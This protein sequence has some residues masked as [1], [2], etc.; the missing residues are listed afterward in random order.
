MLFDGKK[1]H[2]CVNC[3]HAASI[4]ED[5]VLCKYKGIKNAESHCFRFSYEPLKRIPAGKSEMKIPSQG[6][7]SL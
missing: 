1:Y 5:Y 6:D 7:Y 4:D 3:K 2:F